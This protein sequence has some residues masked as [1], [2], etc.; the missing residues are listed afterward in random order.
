MWNIKK[1]IRLIETENGLVVA[2]H[3]MGVGWE[4]WVKGIKRLKKFFKATGEK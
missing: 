1:K 4:E 2:R 3:G